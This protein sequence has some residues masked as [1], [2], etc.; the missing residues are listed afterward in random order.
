MRI[1]LIVLLALGTVRSCAAAD[2]PMDLKWSQLVPAA[3]ASEKPLKPFFSLGRGADTPAHVPTVPE[4]K[5]MSSPT[6]SDASPAPVV[7][8]LDGKRV[9]IG[10]YVVP[11]DI[12]STTVKEFLLV[13]YVGACIHVPP[14]P[15]NQIIYVTSADGIEIGG[16]FDPVYVTGTIKIAVTFTGLA[17]TGYSIVADKVEARAP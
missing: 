11:L 6:K 14:P 12:Q 15:A 3:T 4:G 5:W 8:E 17:E 7:P 16:T 9:R 13:P 1:A 10:G 2:T